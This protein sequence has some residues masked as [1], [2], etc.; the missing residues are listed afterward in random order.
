MNKNSTALF[1]AY[2]T[3]PAL[4]GANAPISAAIPGNGTGFEPQARTFGYSPRCASPI[5]SRS[6]ICAGNSRGRF[7]G[8]RQRH[9]SRLLPRLG[10][11]Q[12]P[13]A[14]AAK[15][16]APAEALGISVKSTSCKVTMICETPERKPAVDFLSG[17][18]VVRFPRFTQETP[19]NHPRRNGHLFFKSSPLDICRGQIRAFTQTAS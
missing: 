1:L 5:S 12:S 15:W 14:T 11:P 17:S 7:S 13:S 6:R 9:Q 10:C 4:P 2:Q 8:R 16:G 19:S 18:L 3:S